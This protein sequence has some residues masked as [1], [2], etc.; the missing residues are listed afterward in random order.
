MTPRRLVG[1]IT[2]IRLATL[3]VAFVVG[4]IVTRDLGPIGRGHYTLGLTISTMIAGFVTLSGDQGVSQLVA[5]VERPQRDVTTS[6]A[7]W[8]SVAMG[9]PAASISVCVALTGAFGLRHGDTLGLAAVALMATV[10]LWGQRLLQIRDQSF[11]AAAISL[12]E[13]MTFVVIAV[14]LV[15]TGTLTPLNAL[16]AFAGSLAVG[17]VATMLVL[18]PRLPAEMGQIALEILTKGL[19]YHPGQVALNLLTRADVLLLGV[20]SSATAVGVYSVGVILTVPLAVVGSAVASTMLGTQLAASR[21]DRIQRTI[22]LV[23]ITFWSVCCLAIVLALLVS[24]A[25]P[26]LWG[27]GFGGGVTATWGLLP[28]VLLLSA[29]RPLGIF[30]VADG[31]S[32]AMNLRAFS[33]LVATCAAGAALI[34]LLAELG[35]ALAMSFG[36]LVYASLSLVKFAQLSRR[37]IRIVLA[38]VA[39]GVGRRETMEVRDA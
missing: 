30:F 2:L 15:K 26:F 7:F 18:R 19:K 1:T 29:Q 20:L 10:Q 16:L 4:I 28:G 22:Q 35:A 31:E 24:W 5:G 3:G 8:L 23:R 39:W 6:V 11:A 9:L 27:P 36:Y 25:V 34:P 13:G 17:C 38:D 12:V 33:G 14:G 21:Q 32:G 37:P